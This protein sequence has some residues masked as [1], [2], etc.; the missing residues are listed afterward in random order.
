MLGKRGESGSPGNGRHVLQGSTFRMAHPMRH[1]LVRMA[2][3]LGLV[4]VCAVAL[5]AVV[6]AQSGKLTGVVRD[7]STN[8]P[9][10]GVEVFIEG[11]GITTFTAANGRFFLLNVP[12]GTVTLVARRLGDQPVRAANVNIAIDVTREVNFSLNSSPATLEA[13]NVAGE[14]VPL[15]EPGVSSSAVGISGDV[16]RALPVVTIEGALRLQQGFLQ[17][18]ENTDIISYTASRRDA[19][20]P[21]RI[22]GG[23]S[24]ETLTLIDGIPVNNWIFGGPPPQTI[25]RRACFGSARARR[26]KRRRAQRRARGI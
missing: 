18:P 12:P 21:I 9:L 3:G 24:G 8:Q 11:S 17:V 23:R 14:A 2:V 20:N 4:A 15:V 5:P 7:Q 22:R 26:R 10:E 19:T 25:P 6:H 1:A 16:I 13:T